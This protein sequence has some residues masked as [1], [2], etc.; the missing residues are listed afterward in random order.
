MSYPKYKPSFRLDLALLPVPYQLSRCR[1]DGLCAPGQLSF[2]SLEVVE[3]L[4]ELTIVVL[5]TQVSAD[6]VPFS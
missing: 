2:R 4:V 1:G 6:F 3:L 5:Q